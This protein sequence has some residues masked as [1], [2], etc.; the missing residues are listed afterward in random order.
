MGSSKTSTTLNPRPISIIGKIKSSDYKNALKN[1]S[2]VINPLHDLEFILDD[3]KL[4]CVAISSIQQSRG[5]YYLTKKF[6]I[7]LICHN[8]FWVN[9]YDTFQISTWNPLLEFPVELI[10]DG[11]E[12]GVRDDNRLISINNTGDIETGI[13]VEFRATGTLENPKIINIYTREVM[14][15]N[16][17]MQHGDIIKINTNYN[18]KRVELIRNN[19]VLNIMHLLDLDSSFIQIPVGESFFKF[20]SE[21]N[22]T[23]LDVS[24]K[25]SSKFVEVPWI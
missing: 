25:Y 20:D 5:E 7:D 24:I 18:E 22:E 16:T 6:K 3:Y 1:L 14:K 23:N 11:L 8:P 2:E 10:E 21:T 17:T 4:N 15:I 12:L 13:E 19:E 9:K